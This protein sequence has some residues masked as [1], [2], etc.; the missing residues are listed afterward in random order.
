MT[1]RVEKVEDE[2]GQLLLEKDGEPSKEYQEFVKGWYGE[3]G[4]CIE[5]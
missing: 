5:E 2:E 3:K 1:A 4:E